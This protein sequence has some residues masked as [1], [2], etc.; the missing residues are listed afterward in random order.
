MGW[1]YIMQLRD[2]KDI[3]VWVNNVWDSITGLFQPAAIRR[4]ETSRSRIR[5]VHRAT[6]TEQNR[7]ERTER[8]A[9]FQAE[10]DRILDKIKAKGYDSLTEAEKDFLYQASN[11]DQ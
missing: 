11:K 10:L 6:S 7:F 4:K 3:G 2:G 8:P 5:V 1:I 9:D